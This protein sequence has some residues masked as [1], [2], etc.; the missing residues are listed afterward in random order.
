[1]QYLYILFTLLN[2]MAPYLLLGFFFAGLLHVFIPQSIFS[3]YLSR[4]NFFSVF[5]AALFGVPLPLCSCG[6]IPAAMALR[7][8]GSSRGAVI[9]FLIATPQT[10]IDSIMATYSLLGFPFAVIRPIAAF[11]TAIL[12][13][14]V[15]NIFLKKEKDDE[16]N[17][18]FPT[19]DIGMT[20]AANK[21]LAALKYGFVD[22][23][24][25]IGKRLILGLL[26]A[27]LITYFV[28]ESF[29]SIFAGSTVLSI[30]FVLLLSIPMY[31]CATGSIPIAI[32]LMMK[33]FSPGT[34]LVLLM[35]GP[36]TNIVSILVISKIL[37]KRSL[38]FYLGSII[39][40]SIIFALIIDFL[41]P[42]A[43]FSLPLMTDMVN[44]H[45]SFY[46]IKV[47]SGIILLVLIINSF[48]VNYLS[49]KRV[50]GNIIGKSSYKVDGMHC[51]NCKNSIIKF[52]KKIDG[53]ESV[54]V[55]LKD[56]IVYIKGNPEEVK[57][58]ETVSSLGFLYK[59]KIGN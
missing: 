2:E 5:A 38:I 39:L 21:I 30:L 48:I 28:P 33:G 47:F 46:W 3:K 36:A 43:W 32:A 9:S 25:D 44:S 15:S 16:N 58:K 19:C 11:V 52:L 54:E 27:A 57:I 18:I 13:G 24:R 23:I 4:N 41:L 56:G 40:G 37:G 20:V 12:G 50:A 22:I 17:G 42:S 31:I 1:M 49:N 34:A 26:L 35:A 6:V 14:F 10:G 7:K 51:E 59:G 29:F 53:V 45:T 8:E 55:N